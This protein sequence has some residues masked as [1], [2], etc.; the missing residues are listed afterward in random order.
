MDRKTQSLL[1]QIPPGSPRSKL[2]P[3]HELIR[4]L[5]QRRK[6]YRQISAL[7]AEHF[8]LTVHYSTI[9]DFVQTHKGKHGE[10]PEP[11]H[12]ALPA[13]SVPDCRFPS[14]LVEKATIGQAPRPPCASQADQ[15]ALIEELKRRKRTP[16]PPQPK[17]RFHYEEGEP[18][19]LVSDRN[20]NPIKR[21]S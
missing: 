17:P 20:T 19:R 18:L 9:Y 12:P 2:E 15:Y 3:H 14:D 7:L 1:D 6:T 4:Q 16:S 11:L 10:S 13:S 21:T 5:R 8:N